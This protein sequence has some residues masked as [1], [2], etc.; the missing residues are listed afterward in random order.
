MS[1]VKLVE[2]FQSFQGEGP[3][4]GKRCVVLRFRKCNRSCPWCDTRVKMED[5]KDI[6]VTHEFIQ[7]EVRREEAG[8]LITGG[9]PTYSTNIL[10]TIKIIEKVKAPW[11]NIESNGY[12]LRTLIKT[13]SSRYI[14]DIKYIFSPKLFSFIDKNRAIK[15]ADYLLRNPRVYIKLVYDP[16]NQYLDDFMTTIG[17]SGHP[18]IYVMP[19]GSTKEELIENSPGAL[20]FAD[21]WKVNFSSRQHILHDF[22]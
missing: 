2:C 20:R 3:D 19:L 14:R 13:T 6:E 5:F 1:S 15:N 22:A 10:E 7:D 16:D 11:I 17:A 9:E 4:S 21:K 12:D 8:L 18:R